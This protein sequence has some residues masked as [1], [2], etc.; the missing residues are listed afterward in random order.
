MATK[1]I[2]VLG[3]GANGASIGAD[4]TRAGLDVVLI[5]QWPEHVQAMRTRGLR[6]EMPE[7]TLHLPGARL[8]PVR[9]LHL[10]RAVRHRAV[11]DQG[12]RHPLVVPADRAVSEIR[13]TRRRRAERHDRRCDRRR[14]RP[15]AHHGLRHRDLVDDVRPGRRPASF[16]TA[17]VVVRG[18]KHLSGERRPRG[19][20]RRSAAARGR[21]RDRRRHS[22]HQVD[23]ARQQCHHARDHRDPR[24]PDARGG[25][26][27]RECAS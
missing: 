5:D 22:R 26:D 21:G 18:R 20:D 25:R 15:R 3:A 17:A 19:R 4:L 12:L 16:A 27:A 14:G 11:G 2:A 24:R 7:E 8:Q 9:R 23:E 1:R 13:R 10:H 6:I